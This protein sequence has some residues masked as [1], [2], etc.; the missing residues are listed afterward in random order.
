LV[1]SQGL[2]VDD[3]NE[4]ALENIPAGGARVDSTTNNLHGQEWG[5][6]GT[7]HR[8]TKHH[9]DVS[10]QILNHSRSDLCNQTK[11]N[12]FLLFFPLDYTENAVVVKQTS[13]TLVGQA[14][15]PL[16]IGEFMRFLGCIFLCYASVE[17][18]EETS[19]PLILSH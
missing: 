2:D 7:C 9:L 3:D 6:N 5:W 19:F 17:L 13:R 11:L 14:Y 15:N 1:R 16:S 10:L 8:K 12:M 18:I 4:P